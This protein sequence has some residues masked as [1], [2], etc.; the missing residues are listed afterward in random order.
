MAPV[1][2]QELVSDTPHMYSD[3]GKLKSPLASEKA[4]N[5]VR[6]G[7]LDVSMASGAIYFEV[8]WS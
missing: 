2:C 1:M 6:E 4:K 3:S 7:N 8:P 5:H